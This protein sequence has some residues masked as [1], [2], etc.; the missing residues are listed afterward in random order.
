MNS[1]DFEVVN[2]LLFRVYMINNGFKKVVS[3]L[4][5]HLDLSF[6]KFMEY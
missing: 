5:F 2:V 4:E 6:K 1:K 3:G